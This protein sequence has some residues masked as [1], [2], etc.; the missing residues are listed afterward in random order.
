MARKSAYGFIWPLGIPC[1]FLVSQNC[2]RGGIEM[3]FLGLFASFFWSTRLWCLFFLTALTLYRLC[4]QLRCSIFE[5]WLGN[6]IFSFWNA[7]KYIWNFHYNLWYI[8]VSVK[9]FFEKCRLWTN[10]WLTRKFINLSPALSFC[11]LAYFIP[12]SMRQLDS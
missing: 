4:F 7:R 3:H 12:S 10:I 6:G 2:G 11:C 5:N 8:T 1:I 9:Y